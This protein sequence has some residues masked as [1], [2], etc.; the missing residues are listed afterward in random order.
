MELGGLWSTVLWGAAEGVGGVGL[1]KRRLRGTSLLSP[2]PWQEVV[3][4]CG[5]ASAP[6]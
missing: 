2:A 1:E 6:E 4:R 5:S 3:V